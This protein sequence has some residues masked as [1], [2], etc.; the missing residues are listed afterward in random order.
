[1][2]IPTLHV[3]IERISL[4]MKNNIGLVLFHYYD[5]KKTPMTLIL[6]S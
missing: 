1:M 3:G 5:N 4:S 6:D 2:G